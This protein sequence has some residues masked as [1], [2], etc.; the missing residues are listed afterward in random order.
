MSSPIAIILAA[1]KSSRMKSK[2]SKP[3]HEVCGRPMLWYLLRACF[4]AGCQKIL[5]VVGQGKDQIIAQCGNDK[6]ISFV[7]QG[8][9]LGTG[10]ATLACRDYLKKHRG[11]VFVLPADAPLIRG[12]ALLALLDGHQH[13][14]A[15]GSMATAIMDNPAGYARVVRTGD[16]AIIVDENSLTREQRE[17]T[18]V[19]P[20]CYCFKAAE[21]LR[22]LP[23]LSKDNR[24]REYDLAEAFA[25]LV[26]QKRN[27]AAVQCLAAEDTLAVNTRQQLAEI[28]LIMQDRIQRQ[29]REDGVTIVNSYNTY[30]EAGVSMG[31]D[32]I[33]YPFSFIGRDST[34]GAQCAIGPFARLPRDTIVPDGTTVIGHPAQ[35]GGLKI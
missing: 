15:A 34:I 27:V 12:Q 17:I 4:E 13:D 26:K 35:E 8:E 30:V 33:V 25:L 22:V 11:D 18:E 14:E 1:G 3:L 32:T 29:A 31:P 2:R 7:E 10:H 5:C 24:R 9:Q 19:A 28:D 6:R 21:L 20:C 16:G 23:K